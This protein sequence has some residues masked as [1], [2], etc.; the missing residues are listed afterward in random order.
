MELTLLLDHL[1]SELERLEVTEMDMRDRKDTREGIL[2]IY[3]IRIK[4]LFGNF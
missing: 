1:A 2:H 4:N 3:E